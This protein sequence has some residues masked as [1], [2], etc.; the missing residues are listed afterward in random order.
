[1]K[2]I[3]LVL[4]VILCGFTFAAVRPAVAEAQ[5]NAAVAI[6]TRDGTSIFRF[7]FKIAHVNRDIVDNTNAA[8]AFASC[9]D[10][11]AIAIA[12]QI[13]LI[14]SDP[15]VVTPTNVAIAI[16]YDC[17]ACVA[18]A[19]AFQWVL[20][21]AGP[22]HFTS[23]GNKQLGEVKKR[24][25][26]LR[27]MEELTLDQLIAELQALA[28]IVGN[29]LENETVSSGPPDPPP[30]SPPPAETTTEPTDTTTTTEPAT[31]TTP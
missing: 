6:N 5:D 11:E 10:C 19:A 12:F 7:A 20:T 2:R 29:V 8:V 9:T 24:L 18:F 1:M 17:S 26:D 27:K 22:F 14:S 15:D 25:H 21:T 4:A 23:E 31:T 28:E 3:A 13:V 30:P 16:N